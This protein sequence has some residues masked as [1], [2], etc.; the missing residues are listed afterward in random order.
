M[1]V[2]ALLAK[3]DTQEMVDKWGR[4]HLFTADKEG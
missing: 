4:N 2:Y 1:S 3:S